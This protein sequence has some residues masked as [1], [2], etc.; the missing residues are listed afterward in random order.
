MNNTRCGFIA[1]IGVPNAGKSTLVNQLVGTKISIVTR[2]EQT[3]RNRVMG[4]FIE[5]ESQVI[6][7]DTPGIFNPKIRFERAMVKAAWSAVRDADLTAVIVDVSYKNLNDSIAI[8][9][10]LNEQDIHPM[11]ILNKVDLLNR[12]ELLKITEKMVTGRQIEEV[13]MISAKNGDGVDHL[14]K[15]FAEKLPLSP[16]HFPEDQITDIPE[17]LLAAEIT[18]EKIFHYLHQE[19]PYSIAIETESWEEFDNGSVKITQTIYVQKPNQKAIVLGKGGHQ[20]KLIGE[21]ARSEITEALGRPVHLFLHVKVK[22][23]WAEKPQHYNLLGL[24]FNV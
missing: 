18:R 19:L 5:N 21:K 11:L 2:K 8:V 16:W 15:V 23:N 17:R 20:V 22:E 9:D 3:T 13:F 1:I 6:L 12:D 10:L 14:R 7:V 24:D 4:I